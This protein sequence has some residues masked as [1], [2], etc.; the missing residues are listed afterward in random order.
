[1]EAQL[2]Q[3]GV[4]CIVTGKTQEPSLPGLILPTQD[5]HGHNEPLPQAVLIL[6]SEI[7]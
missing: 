4:F 5:T 1:M 3:F 6:N 2:R 7:H